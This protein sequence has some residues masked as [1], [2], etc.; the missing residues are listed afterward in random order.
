M[1]VSDRGTAF[2]SQEFSDFLMSREIK[3]RQ[4]AVAAPWTN[5]VVERVNR[6][7]KSSLKK[8]VEDPTSW[9]S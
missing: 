3:H 5:G 1:L 4:V 7:L 6:F 2:T 9:R 8:L